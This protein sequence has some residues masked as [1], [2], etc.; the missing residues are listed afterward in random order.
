[1]ITVMEAL[2]NGALAALLVVAAVFFY[3][4]W[5]ESRDFL[6]LAFGASFLIRAINTIAVAILQKPNEGTPL[7]Y[8]I[9]LTSTLFIVIAIIHKNLKS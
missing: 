2:A 9:G 6:F 4:F 8:L 5:R 3:R 1:M 7:N